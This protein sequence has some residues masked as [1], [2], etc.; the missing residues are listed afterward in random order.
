MKAKYMKYTILSLTIA[1]LISSCTK[2]SV[3]EP[4]PIILISDISNIDVTS[5]SYSGVI[6]NDGGTLVTERGICWKAGTIPTIADNK[7]VNGDGAGTFSGKITGLTPNTK[8]YI[9]AYATNQAGTNYG[10]YISFTTLDGA[11][12]ADGNVYHAVTIGSQTWLAENLKTTK[13]ND[14]TNIALLTN[15][16][17]WQRTTEGAYSWFNYDGTTYIATYGPLYNWYA[18]NSGKLCPVG[19][20]VPSD[21]EWKT[22]EIYLQNHDYN[23][24]SVIDTDNFDSTNNYVAKSLASISGWNSSTNM[25]ATGNIDFQTYR[26]KSGFNAF[27][28]GL[29]YEDGSCLGIGGRTYWW[30]STELWTKYAWRRGID[31]LNNSLLKDYELKNTGLSV[32][33]VKN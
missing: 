13:Y 2:D 8:Y 12:D 19:W 15:G 25:G 4:L 24:N 10:S 3:I 20:H 28:A 30:S 11:I 23:F 14:N 16:G 6:S 29:R 5:A 7:T 31:A 18:V 9:R 26:N 17:V 33:C 22:L 1:I 21:T 27:P 32:R